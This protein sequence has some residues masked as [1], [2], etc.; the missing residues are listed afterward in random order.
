MTDTR[1]PHIVVTNEP[2]AAT[3]REYPGGGGGFKREPTTLGDHS[4][5]ISTEA[6]QLR[7]FFANQ[8]DLPNTSHR[9][10]RIELPE[11][12]TV[13]GAVEETIREKLHAE[14]VSSPAKNI[15][16]ISTLPTAF[17][18]LV[19]GINEYATTPNHDGKSKYALVE[20]IKPIPFDEKA[21]PRTLLVDD[22][23]ESNFVVS[24]HEDL[25][26]NE[27]QAVTTRIQE[28][29][30]A[31][32]GRIENQVRSSNGALLELKVSKRDIRRISDLIMA[33]Q[34]V[35]LNDD[36]ITTSANL[37]EQIL[38]G[39]VV[40]NNESNAKVCIFDM[41]VVTGSRLLNSSLIGQ[42]NAFGQNP[43]A[44]FL[45]HG[46][47]VASRIIYGDNLRQ[48]YLANR[49]TP[50][51]KVY[52]VDLRRFDH[53]GNIKRPTALELIPIIREFVERN[54]ETYKVY[55]LSFNGVNLLYLNTSKVSSLAA[56]LDTLSC[57]FNVIFVISSGNF[58]LSATLPEDA[59]PQYFA[60]EDTSL[61]MP[62]ESSLSL[63]VGSHAQHSGEGAMADAPFPSP[64][65]RRGPGF[66]GDLKPDVLA[67]GGNYIEGWRPYDQYSA[68]GID[69]SGRHL[70]YGNG[71]SYSAPIISRLAAKT[72]ELIPTASACLVRALIIHSAKVT[73]FTAQDFP[74]FEHVV[75]NGIPSQDDIF[76]SHKHRQVFIFD[77]SLGF[78][79]MREIPF[80][81]PSVLTQRSSKKGLGKVRIRV[82]IVTAPETSLNLE[83][84]YCKSHLRT[85]ILKIGADGARKDV[86]FSDTDTMETGRYR[87]IYQ[88]DKSFSTKVSPGEWAIFV[89][90]ESRWKLKHDRLR[91][92]V[93]VSVEDPLQA[94]NVD[95]HAA[96]RT[97]SR[98]R[99]RNELTIQQG[100][101]VRART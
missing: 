97:E 57:K 8:R 87:S 16:H 61:L 62:A 12:Q 13:M 46:T 24:L 2:P 76:S 54:H 28:E 25:T 65:T 92:A 72:F 14:I 50:D 78:R 18:D 40:G 41:G 100:T 68:A 35:D 79:E 1:R 52:S 81:V 30:R 20:S 5:R 96:I 94:D 80:F 22:A 55:N 99:F 63:T 3:V 27:V 77:G 64:F 60:S 85:K 49:F 98:T 29:I 39:A 26:A 17:D 7:A 101:R 42:H 95:V 56:E 91:Y 37:G 74:N 11:G 58:P 43:P 38:D 90:H 34:S 4:R 45:E 47:F 70:A 59:Y 33:I 66:D 71:T 89:A 75:G 48:Q 83:S 15:A 51:V 23:V 69:S 31:S 6:A 19:R 82:T 36:I 21:S 9:Y 67:H 86:G 10:F 32:G 44:T 73:P 84:G 88:M 93:V 53:L